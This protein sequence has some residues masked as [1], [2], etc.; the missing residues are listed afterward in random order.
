MSGQLLIGYQVVI[1]IYVVFL[2]FHPQSLFFFV[3][4]FFNV[5]KKHHQKTQEVQVD[6]TACPEW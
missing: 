4:V 3:W 6:Q 5:A 1:F 2:N